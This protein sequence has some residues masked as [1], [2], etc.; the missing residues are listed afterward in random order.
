MIK[1]TLCVLLTFLFVFS[2]VSCNEDF[3]DKNNGNGEN[4][5]L[6]DIGIMLDRTPYDSEPE[7]SVTEP[8][9]PDSSSDSSEPSAPDNPSAPSNPS[10]PSNPD[11]PSQGENGN[12]DIIKCLEALLKGYKLNPKSVIPETML[13]E[14]AD[15][16]ITLDSAV[17]DYSQS[18]AIS[19]IPRS[20]VG[21]QW[22]MI[23]ENIEQSQIFFNSLS[24]IDGLVTVSVAEFNNY[25]NSSTGNNAL[26]NFVSDKYS[27]TIKCNQNVIY[28]ILEYTANLPKL[29]EQSVQ[30]A[31]CMDMSSQVKNVR[32]QLGDSNALAYKITD[33]GYSFALKLLGVRKSYF[34]VEQTQK[35]NY[36]G[37][38]YEYITVSSKEIA[39]IADFYI[40]EDYVTVVGDK[41]DGMAVFDGSI[42]EL[43]SAN[44][45]RMLAYEVNEAKAS[46]NYDTLWFNLY[47]V[48][49]LEFIKDANAGTDKDPEFYLNG[50]SEKW[51]NKKVG[52]LS[53]DVAFSRRYDIEYRTQYFY[54]YD[55]ESETVKKIALEVPMLFVQED[56][57]ETLA[58]DI[59]SKNKIDVSISLS[60]K[61]VDK[62]IAEYDGKI[63]KL[64]ENKEQYTSEMIVKYIGNRII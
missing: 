46:I 44:T 24:V 2:M 25:L 37:H 32:I 10:T 15:N 59:K 40:T 1:K 26:H 50:S 61:H 14:Y 3:S 58:A 9:V 43:Y 49:G 6:D 4:D 39:S 45:G 62:L 56:N 16:Q 48:D 33:N 42:C 63:S 34:E 51:E 18:V 52:G 27:V 47:D 17:T 28:Y 20:G 12:V 22:N 41:A 30:I 19:K 5:S 64:Y 36:V 35:G 21:E 60:E 53:L 31:L 7:N 13:P 54:Y 57:Y 11:N 8:S 55:A 23:I 38:V 29:G